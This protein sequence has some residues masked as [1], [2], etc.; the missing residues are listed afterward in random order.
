MCNIY[1]LI[2]NF[3]QLFFNAQLFFSIEESSTVYEL[4]KSTSSPVSIPKLKVALIHRQYLR[5]L[6]SR[7]R[8]RVGG[9]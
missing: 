2:L 1:N 4:P 6:V 9:P 3:G 7:Q 5:V 8:R